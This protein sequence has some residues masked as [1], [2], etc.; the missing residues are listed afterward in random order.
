MNI[1]CA[2]G[3]HDWYTIGIMS[4]QEIWEKLNHNPKSS[5]PTYEPQLID[6]EYFGDRICVRCGKH[7]DEI[8]KRRKYYLNILHMRA[9]SEDKARSVCNTLGIAFQNKG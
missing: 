4:E 7:V 9:I 6:P 1:K 5:K 3:I 2:L 8:E